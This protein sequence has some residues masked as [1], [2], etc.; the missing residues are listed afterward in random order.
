MD[1]PALCNKPEHCAKID[2]ARQQRHL[3]RNEREKDSRQRNLEPPPRA[4]SRY[5]GNA[6]IEYDRSPHLD[7][8]EEG[9]AHLA[10]GESGAR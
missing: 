6:F 8:V 9:S 1:A 10:T 3:R 2:L 5:T 7:L 4:I